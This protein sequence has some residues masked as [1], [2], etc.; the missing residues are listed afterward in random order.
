MRPPETVPSADTKERILDAAEVLLA[1]NGYEATSLRA[2][3]QAAGVNLAAV[4]Y[5]F[6][7][8]KDLL[9][10]VIRRVAEPVSRS[11][12]E[13][14]EALEASSDAPSVE[15]VLRAF[16][17]PVFQHLQDSAARGPTVFLLLSRVISDPDPRI[18]N[19]LAAAFGDVGQ[20]FIEHLAV[21]LPHL[22]EEELWW[23]FKSCIGV[24]IFHQSRSLPALSILG[25]AP[26]E[27]NLEMTIAFVTAGMSA[28]STS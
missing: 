11:R 14:L 23:R 8:K 19:M 27:R 1:E 17:E 4:N 18:Q 22:D 9:D 7:S 2:V 21:L 10:A 26:D 3:T 16:L 6:G 25:S 13:R 5:H 15:A 24:A 12:L 28:P 20:R